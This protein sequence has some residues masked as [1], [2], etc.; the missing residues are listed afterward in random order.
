MSPRSTPCSIRKLA[1]GKL[2]V[3]SFKRRK[4]LITH[5]GTAERGDPASAMLRMLTMLQMKMLYLLYSVLRGIQQWIAA[6]WPT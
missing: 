6:T 2:A 3:A 5:L 1:Y 4:L